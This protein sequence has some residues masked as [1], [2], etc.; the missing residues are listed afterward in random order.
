MK[1][2]LVK[3][4]MLLSLLSG[5]WLVASLAY[6]HEYRFGD[7]EIDH[8]YTRAVPPTAQVGAGYM[9]LK[10]HGQDSVRL[11]GG[12]VPFARKVEIHAMSQDEGVMKMQKVSDGVD[13]PAGGEV[14]FGPGG[15]HLMFIQLTESMQAGD[16]HKAV[17]E[18]TTGKVDVVFN[19]EEMMRQSDSHTGH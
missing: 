10:N 1:R 9:T 5:L 4:T 13:I 18:F 11:L 3:K 2:A 8:L 6:G 16:K 17:L 14:T 12:S 7:V 19:V 15:Y